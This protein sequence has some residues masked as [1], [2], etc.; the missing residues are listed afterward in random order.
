MGYNRRALLIYVCHLCLSTH[1]ACLC[2][3]QTGT[4]LLLQTRGVGPRLANAR[5]S[6]G[7]APGGIPAHGSPV[8]F[9]LEFRMFTSQGAFYFYGLSLTNLC[10]RFFFQITIILSGQSWRETAGSSGTKAKTICV[11]EYKDGKTGTFP[12]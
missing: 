12:Q 7:R 11:K 6:W 8:A 2:C 10:F 3:L 1:L 9:N 4:T 5:G